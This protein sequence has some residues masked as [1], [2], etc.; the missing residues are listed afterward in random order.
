MTERPA[1][2]WVD[3]DLRVQVD[4][5]LGPS[6]DAEGFTYRLNCQ[7]WQEHRDRTRIA[8]GIERLVEILSTPAPAVVD[9]PI[10][11]QLARRHLELAMGPDPAELLRAVMAISAELRRV[12]V[13]NAQLRERLAELERG[14]AGGDGTG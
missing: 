14:G 8:R 4:E 3:E 11:D 7:L 5:S 12:S 9:D 2:P 10:I 13:E 1:L 6:G